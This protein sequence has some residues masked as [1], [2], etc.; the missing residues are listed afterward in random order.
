MIGILEFITG[1]KINE[2][3]IIKTKVNAFSVTEGLVLAEK[4]ELF[5]SLFYET[6]C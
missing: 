1:R 5:L 4:D 3:D 2:D 6:F